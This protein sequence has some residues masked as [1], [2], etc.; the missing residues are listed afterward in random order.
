[1]HLANKTALIT[2]SGSTGGIGAEIA[3]VFAR[4]GASIVLSGRD[5]ARGREVANELERSGASVRFITADLADVAE[6]KRLAAEAGDIDILVNN[7]AGISIA[8]VLAQSVEGFDNDF[9]V[10]VRATFFLTAAVGRSMANRGSGSVINFSST[11]AQ[12][13][14]AGSAVYSATKAAIDSLTRS[15]A[16]ELGDSGV[17][18]NAIAPSATKTDQLKR[19]MGD[20]IDHAGADS[21]LKRAASTTE[22]ANVALFLA[23]ESSSFITGTTILADGGTRAI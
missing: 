15:F 23:S 13:V 12:Y 6:V 14:V 10:S 2:G 3:R 9:A 4:E 5:E 11:L 18:V 16:L 7:A 1:M 17:R 20:A 8:P 19:L 22:I 21:I